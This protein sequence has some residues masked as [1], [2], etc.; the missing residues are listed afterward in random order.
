M[1]VHVCVCVCVH[2]TDRESENVQAL[3]NVSVLS[4]FLQF[5]YLNVI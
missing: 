3:S 5:L 2:V 1:C 4:V